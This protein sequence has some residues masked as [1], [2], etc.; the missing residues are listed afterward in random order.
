MSL[1]VCRQLPL[2]SSNIILYNPRVKSRRLLPWHMVAIGGRTA[3]ALGSREA[4]IGN[5]IAART[6]V[7]LNQSAR[8]RIR[9]IASNRG[10][11]C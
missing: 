6:Y 10:K 2:N 8:N 7:R 11:I 4:S 9:G 5:G 1:T 3:R